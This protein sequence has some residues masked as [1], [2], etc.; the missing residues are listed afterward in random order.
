MIK[1]LYMTHEY[2]S[3]SYYHSDTEWTWSNSNEGLLCVPQNVKAE[4]STLDNL[5]SYWGLT[6]SAKMIFFLNR[7]SQ[8]FIWCIIVT[9]FN[10][11]SILVQMN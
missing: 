4:A 10:F 5:V 6:R 11:H 1:V 3:N 2:D 8:T 7:A 9:K